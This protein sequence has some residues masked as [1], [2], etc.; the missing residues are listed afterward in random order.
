MNSSRSVPFWAV[1][2]SLPEHWSWFFNNRIMPKPTC[3][4][5]THWK[6][7]VFF[8]HSGHFWASSKSQ[9]HCEPVCTLAWQ[10]PATSE[11]P[12]RFVCIFS[13]L[14]K[15]KIIVRLRRAVG[16]NCPPDS[17]IQ[18]FKSDL[19][20]AKK[21]HTGWCVSFLLLVYTLDISVQPGLLPTKNGKFWIFRPQVST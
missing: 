8:V 14:W 13:F 19:S 12:A 15:E 10:S 7:C 6:V 4:K 2:W 21:T 16:G 17:C 3:K 18:I 11:V 9:C 5:D 20:I 1:F